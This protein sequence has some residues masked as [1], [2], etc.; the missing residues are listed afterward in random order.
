[1]GGFWTFP[2]VGSLR[3]SILPATKNHELGLLNSTSQVVSQMIE[4]EDHR[5]LKL[6]H[7]PWDDLV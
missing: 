5:H 6:G 1:M 3:K 4:L 2:L 7:V